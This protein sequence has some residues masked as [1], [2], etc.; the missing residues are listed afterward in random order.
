MIVDL[1]LVAKL[2]QLPSTYMILT[3]LSHV[4]TDIMKMIP[5]I[6]VPLVTKTVVIV[7]VVNPTN[8]L[9]VVKVNSYGKVNVTKSVQI[10]YMVLTDTVGH[11]TNIVDNV[12]EVL[13][14]TVP[15]VMLIDSYTITLVLKLAQPVSMII[16]ILLPLVTTTVKLVTLNVKNVLVV[17]I[18]VV[19]VVNSQD[20]YITTNVF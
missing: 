6:P 8:V 13:G 9:N 5:I 14:I 2:A 20:I 17:K 18:L 4:H 10:T 7:T 12:T 19:M 16:L 15:V 11:V 3:V 1:K